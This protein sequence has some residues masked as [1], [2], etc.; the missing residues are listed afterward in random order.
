MVRVSVFPV[1]N[2]FTKQVT[3]SLYTVE[4]VTKDTMPWNNKV[5]LTY[6]LLVALGFAPLGMCIK[7]L[8][9]QD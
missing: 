1:T 7:V 4:K 2:S 8:F 5:Q 9:L 3:R 6:Q